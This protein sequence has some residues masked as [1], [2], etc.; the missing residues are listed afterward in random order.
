MHFWLATLRKIVLFSLPWKA[1]PFPVQIHITHKVPWIFPIFLINQR[2]SLFS[3]L[4]GRF[5]G[6]I[7]PFLGLSLAWL[8]HFSLSTVGPARVRSAAYKSR[9]A[10]AG[11]FDLRPTARLLI[12]PGEREARKTQHSVTT[13]R[14]IACAQGASRL[15]FRRGHALGHPRDPAR[16]AT[17]A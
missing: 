4:L 3:G 13:A 16:P 6:W 12:S 17:A 15:S 10:C 2:S 7:T 14:V 5:T 8:V 1:I 9:L 11:I